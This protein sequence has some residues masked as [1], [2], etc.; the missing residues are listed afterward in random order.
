MNIGAEYTDAG[1]LSGG[2][3]DGHE[4]VVVARS[5]P[6]HAKSNLKTSLQR[7]VQRVDC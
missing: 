6:E 2:G 5:E 7:A 3:G 1:D 4:F